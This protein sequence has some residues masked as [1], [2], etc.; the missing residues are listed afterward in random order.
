MFK[1]TL[2]NNLVAPYPVAKKYATALGATA[3]N[4]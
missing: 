2:G 3:A 4:F 1:S